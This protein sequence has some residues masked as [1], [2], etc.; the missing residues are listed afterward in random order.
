[1]PRLELPE[2]EEGEPLPGL[3]YRAIVDAMFRGE[4]RSGEVVSELSLARKLG[5]SRTPVH[6]AIRD[7][8]HD[9]LIV[10]AS[11]QRP[12]IA[13]MSTADLREIFEMRILLEGEAAFRAAGM[14]DRPTITALK[15]GKTELLKTRKNLLERWT[16]YDDD[17]HEAIARGSGH[18]RLCSDILRYRNIHYA[19]NSVR[20]REDLV[21][22]ALAEHEAILSAIDERDGA[23]AREAMTAHLREW[24]AYYVNAFAAENESPRRKGA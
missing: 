6:I 21:P 5:V 4:L 2:G 23:R 1:M 13:A 9:G 3:V 10:Q 18:R 12:T 20:M 14:M 15:Q 19:L 11:G 7:L 17:F 24:Q 16:R 8:A 22:Q